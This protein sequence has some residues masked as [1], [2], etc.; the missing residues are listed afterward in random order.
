M[1][2]FHPRSRRRCTSPPC[3]AL[4]LVL[5]SV[6]LFFAAH[7][8]AQAAPNGCTVEGGTATSTIQQAVSNSCSEIRVKP[9]TYHENVVI[10]AA[11]TVSITGMAGAAT[12]IVDGGFAG[13]VFTIN[14]GT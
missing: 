5:T 8:C 6:S 10:P 12:T 4:A 11:R 1:N 14:S 3:A 7:R 13:S 2:S 9:G